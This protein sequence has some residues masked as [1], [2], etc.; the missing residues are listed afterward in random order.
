[1]EKTSN[2]KENSPFILTCYTVLPSKAITLL[3]AYKSFTW[4][5]LLKIGPTAPSG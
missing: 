5:T 3:L 2:K 1:M 4:N